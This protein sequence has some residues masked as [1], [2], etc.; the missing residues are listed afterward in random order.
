MIYVFFVEHKQHCSRNLDPV[1]S[2]KDGCGDDDDDDD[3]NGN[4]VTISRYESSY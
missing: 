4:V 1:A 3:N 2:R